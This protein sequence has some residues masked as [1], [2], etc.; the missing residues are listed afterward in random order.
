MSGTE[1]EAH[2]FDHQLMY[3]VGDCEMHYRKWQ[4]DVSVVKGMEKCMCVFA[5]YISKLKYIEYT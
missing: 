4:L 3:Y 1:L 5:I 2:I